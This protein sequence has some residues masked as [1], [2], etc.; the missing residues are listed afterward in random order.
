MNK[1]LPALSK[2]PSFSKPLKKGAMSPSKSEKAEASESA[3]GSF[4][5][6]LNERKR[7]TLVGFE[8]FAISDQQSETKTFKTYQR[9][10]P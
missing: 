5:L 7:G 6:R 10:L 1:P 8:G 3:D 4:I 2:P 9:P